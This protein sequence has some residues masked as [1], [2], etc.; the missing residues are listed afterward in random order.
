M[1]ILV[2]KMYP[3]A[4]LPTRATEGAAGYDL[5]A[6][7]RYGEDSDVHSFSR[8]GKA[9]VHVCASH[10][11]NSKYGKSY[12]FRTG[13]AVAIPEGYV[14]LLFPRSGWATKRQIRLSNCVGVIDSDFRDEIIVCLTNDGFMSQEV[15]DG[16]RIAQLVVIKYEELEQE[17]VD[18]LPPT[19]RGKGKFGSTGM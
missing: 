16:D 14:G 1:K 3:D 17:V 19:V 8:D 9:V 2:Q 4:K 12:C 11:P 6:Y 18:A 10:E 7:L 13:I 15:V 5:Y